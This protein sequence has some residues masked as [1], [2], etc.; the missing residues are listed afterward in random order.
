MRQ[1]KAKCGATASEG[2]TNHQPIKSMILL[3]SCLTSSFCKSLPDRY[4]VKILSPI[5]TKQFCFNLILGNHKFA[6]ILEYCNGYSFL[7]MCNAH[8]VQKLCCLL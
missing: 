8:Y 6:I 5:I 3:I 4:A 2:T 1:S 7:I